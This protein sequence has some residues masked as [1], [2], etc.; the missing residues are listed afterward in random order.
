MIPETL[1][2]KPDFIGPAYYEKLGNDLALFLE[3]KANTNAIFLIAKNTALSTLSP[4]LLPPSSQK[5]LS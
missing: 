3:K 4:L 5:M 2:M 1:I